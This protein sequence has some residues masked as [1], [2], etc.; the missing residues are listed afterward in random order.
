[1]EF[2]KITSGERVTASQLQAHAYHFKYRPESKDSPETCRA[3]FDDQGHMTACLECFN[4]QVWF[5]GGL[6]GMSGIGGVASLP[7][8]RRSG[9]VRGLFH[10][11]FEEQRARGDVF[12]YLFPF[13]HPYYRRFGYEQCC[14]ARQVTMPLDDLLSF[15]SPGRAE[16]YLPEASLEPIQSI[17]NAYARRYNLMADRT[18]EQWQDHF[19][20]SPYEKNRYTY[21]WY[22]ENERPAGYFQYS[23]ERNKDRPNTISID[24]MAWRDQAG[25]RGMLGFMGRLYVGGD[26]DKATVIAGP[27]FHPELLLSEPYK[28]DIKQEWLGMCRIIDTQ[29]ALERMRKPAGSGSAVVRVIDELAP[30]NAGRW[31]VAW[32]DGECDVS[33]TTQNPDLTCAVPA[34]AQ[35]VNGYMAFHD[36]SQRQD[37]ELAGDCEML[38][39]LFPAKKILVAEFY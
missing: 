29:R 10:Y 38:A 14:I 30:W 15:A 36:L 8:Y 18:P 11:I 3:A 22:D 26:I 28:L 37:M 32:E 21:I 35:L 23:A 25:L 9:H 34:L 24:E 31:R 5:D 20:G 17:Y 19:E 7:V 33:A 2:R 6:V 27:D 12:S 4:F 1:M 39:R 13:S 16:L